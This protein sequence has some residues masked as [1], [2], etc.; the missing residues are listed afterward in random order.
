MVC[1]VKENVGQWDHEAE[2]EDTGKGK[3]KTVKESKESE[4]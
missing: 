2:G 3:F 4:F 1:K